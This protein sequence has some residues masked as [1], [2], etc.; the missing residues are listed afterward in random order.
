[1]HVTHLYA[2]VCMYIRGQSQTC[3]QEHARAGTQCLE[4]ES[5]GIE[6]ALCLG[7]RQKRHIRSRQAHGGQRFAVSTNPRT[8]AHTV[9]SESHPLCMAPNLCR[10]F[11]WGFIPLFLS[12]ECMS[13]HVHFVMQ[14]QPV[15]QARDAY[16][17]M[18][19]QNLGLFFSPTK[20]L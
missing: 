15:L 4:A 8:H 1:M 3:S 14:K 19:V 10:A 13:S 20:A 5:V 7:S 2:Y 17:Y 18:C 9:V 6:A 11:M 16:T 12:G